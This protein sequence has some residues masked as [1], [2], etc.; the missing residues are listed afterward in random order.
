VLIVAEANDLHAAAMAAVLREHHGID[1]IRLDLHDFPEQVSS[2]RMGRTAVSASFGGIQLDDVQSVWWRRPRPCGV[3]VSTSASDDSYRQAECDS[4]IQGLLL[5]LPV[6][7][8]NDPRAE[9][10]ANRKIVQ[11]RAAQQLGLAVPE[12]LITNEPE[13]ARAF[14]ESRPHAVICK[15][16]GTT[17]DFS[18]TRIVT[19]R[20]MTRLNSIRSSPTIFQDYIEAD[21]DLR[22]A[23][24]GGHEC[25]VRIDS[26]SGTGRVDSRLDSSVDFSPCELPRSVGA[27]L[28]E[29]M[30]SLGLIFGVIDIRLGADGQYY[31]L[32]VNP[33]GQFAYMQIK[34]GMPI[35][36]PL[37]DLLVTGEAAFGDRSSYGR[38]VDR[39][40]RGRP[41]T[42]SSISSIS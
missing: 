33:Q 11:L 4:F 42:D 34:T 29:L 21:A 24:V 1:A 7:W 6:R 37:A 28:S 27:A 25:T 9:R 36:E 23:W 2:F 32:E 17:R 3:P 18:P 15:R 12:T 30:A 14:I 10:T 16:V 19:E 22:I 13:E 39:N 20:D 41:S 31:F 26:Q 40:V 38:S 35:F 5:S 8:V